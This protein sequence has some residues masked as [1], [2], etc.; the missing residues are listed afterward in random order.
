ML[1]R[2]NMVDSINRIKS[3]SIDKNFNPHKLNL[4]LPSLNGRLFQFLGLF[5]T[6]LK[7]FVVSTNGSSTVLLG[8]NCVCKHGK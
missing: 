7:A 3:C 2:S 8:F 4:F 1:N 6:S 5:N